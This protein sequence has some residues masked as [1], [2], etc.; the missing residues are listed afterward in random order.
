[1]PSALGW[2]DLAGKRVGIFGAGLEGASALERLDDLTDDVVVVDDDPNATLPDHAVIDMANGGVAAL[3]SC[4]VVIKAP[5]ISRYRSEVQALEAEGIAVVGG[6]GLSVHDLG[7]DRILAVTGTKG[8]STTASI[9]GHLAAA[10]GATTTVTG[11]IGLP[12]FD[13][14]IP[15][16]LDLYIVETS[17]FQALDFADAPRVVV[18]TSLAVDH[19]DW[20]GSAEQYQA[21]KL[22]L[23]SLPG[24]GITIAQGAS[25]ELRAHAA[26]L[27]GDVRWSD[28]PVGT[29]A[30][31]LG[32]IGE[33][34][35]ANA[36]LARCAL[37]AWGFEEASNEQKLK[38]ASEGF[39]PLPGRLSEAGLIDGVRFVDDSLATNVLPT[40]AALQA[41]AEDR[42]AILIG[43]FDRGINYDA[44]VAALANREQPTLVIGLPDSGEQLVER[45]L[46]QAPESNALAVANVDE[47][48]RLAFEW[49]K[50]DGTVLLSPAAPSFSQF[51]N[52]KER[53]SAFRKAVDHLRPS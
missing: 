36:E 44:L 26:L 12:L 41:F 15:S 53:S 33:H 17:S 50:P 32:L 23:T 7:A 38:V 8:K 29:W 14:A 45:I 24:A 31:P 25:S 13:R 1:M 46:R 4:D 34:N 3:F 19:V 22:S 2:G 47:A 42:L 9:V 48:T 11:N 28:A 49:S 35:L 37:D 10:F 20:H 43:G 6:T 39:S 21:D 16:D 30:E 27:G 18:V 40:L 52:W 5:G 51:A